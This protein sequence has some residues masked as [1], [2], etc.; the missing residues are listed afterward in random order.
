[1]KK[2]IISILLTA[3]M[4]VCLVPTGAF[5]ADSTNTQYP[6]IYLNTKPISNPTKVQSGSN[7]H[8]E[9]NSYIYFGDNGGEPIK[10]RVLDA[11]KANDGSKNGMFLM[12]EYLLDNN[13][14]YNYVH[15][16]SDYNG[17]DAQWWCEGF[18]ANDARFSDLERE[19]MLSVE[20]NDNVEK[21]LFDYTWDKCSL[22]DADKM[23]F[24]SIRE[25][26]DYVGNYDKAPG[27]IAA[28]TSGNKGTWWLR[29]HPSGYEKAAGLIY[30]TGYVD[31]DNVNTVHSARPALNLNKNNISFISAAVGGKSAEGTDGGLVEIPSYSGNEW[32]LTLYDSSR[33]DFYVDTKAVS[34][35][36][37]GGEISIRYGYAKNGRN[38]YISAILF[39]KDGNAKYYG[40]SSVFSDPIFSYVGGSGK[41]QIP[42]GLAEGEY[43]FVVFSEQY[44]GDYKTDYI[45]DSYSVR[46][47]VEKK[48]EEQFSLATGERYYFDL[49][50]FNFPG[51]TNEELPDSTLR[52]V[53]FIYAGTVNSYVL[54][55]ESSTVKGSSEYASKITDPSLSLYGYTYPHSLF[56]AEHTIK[57]GVMWYELQ[58]ASC[59]Y[60]ADYQ[61]GGIDY[62]LRAPTV[63]SAGNSGDGGLPLRNEWDR[64]LDKNSNFIKNW[65]G[66]GSWGQDLVDSHEGVDYSVHRG[67]GKS[68]RNWVD[69]QKSSYFLSSCY[70]P[71]LEVKNADALGRNGLR[72][73]TLNFNGTTVGSE[74]EIKIVVKSGG[75][76]TAPTNDGLER[77]YGWNYFGWLGD[78]NRVYA[79]GDSVPENVSSLTAQWI[80]PEEFRLEY[81]VGN[82][83]YFDLSGEDIPGTVDGDLPDT[84]LHYVP[85]TY[86]GTIEAYKLKSSSMGVVEAAEIASEADD[87]ESMYGYTQL[88]SLF[89]ADR[90]LTNRVSWTELDKKGLIF[91][92]DYTSNGINYT[93]RAPSMGSSYDENWNNLPSNNE[94]DR[95]L[96]K[97]PWYIKNMEIKSGKDLFF[98]WGQDTRIND[99]GTEYMVLRYEKTIGNR[100][101]DDA[102]DGAYRPVLEVQNAAAL[103]SDGL[104]EVVLYLDGGSLDGNEYINLMVKNS[105]SFTAPSKEGL[106]P[107]N[108]S[109]VFAGWVDLSS[110]TVYQ[111]GDSVPSTVTWLDATW[112][113]HTHCICGGNAY[114]GHDSH[115]NIDWKPWTATDSLPTEAGY[116]FLLNDVTLSGTVTLPDGVNICLNGNSI[117]GEYANS[118][119]L[120][121]SGALGI[122]D[123]S[124]EGSIGE[125]TLTGNGAELTLYGGKVEESTFL[126][127]SGGTA[128]TITGKA[129]SDGFIR[130]LDDADFTMN[131]EAENNSI[132]YFVETSSD[133][134]IKFGGHAKGGNVFSESTQYGSVISLD[135]SAEI[136]SLSG[137]LASIALYVKNDAKI[138]DVS[139]ITFTGLSLSENAKAGSEDSVFTI[140]CRNVLLKDNVQL[141]GKITYGADRE[142]GML[143]LQDKASIS[144]NLTLSN[145]GGVKTPVKVVMNGD[146]TVHG[147]IQC[148]DEAVSFEMQ[149]NAKIDGSIDAANSVFFGTVTCGGDI[150]SGV[151]DQNGTVINN[152]RIVGGIFYGTVMGTG[153]IEQS[154]KRTVTFVPNGGMLA[155]GER[156]VDILRGQKAGLPTTCHRDGYTLAGW[157][158]GDAAYDFST[159]VLEEITLTA[160]WTANAYTVKFDA[161]VGLQTADKVLHWEDKVLDGVNAPTRN[162]GYKFV[163]WMCGGEIVDAD[164]TYEKLAENDTVKSIT[165]TAQWRDIEKPVGEIVVKDNIWNKLLNSITFGLFFKETQTVTITASDNS[166]GNVT[167]EYLY[168]TKEH[169]DKEMTE[170]ELNARRVAAFSGRHC[171]YTKLLFGRTTEEEDCDIIDHE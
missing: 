145:A 84:S 156:A 107:P 103:G 46:F 160:Q 104:K 92:R 129:Q 120:N 85:F 80:E 75:S 11:D 153:T 61:S 81:G 62:T 119:K 135:G 169:K 117:K 168:L 37:D 131:G 5:A 64:I 29:S 3:C 108:D 13:V 32:K 6:A 163:H 35:T 18:V 34:V 27:F 83:Y 23:F 71:V 151:F 45:S 16:T 88:H 21:T 22:T 44:N 90:T 51:T 155:M 137:I 100:Q 111:P 140:E 52:Y 159:P 12:S 154:A 109:L 162:D 67:D 91:G 42:A 110:G 40:R 78:N 113:R 10:W 130:V 31:V 73:V 26:I 124:G 50:S 118:T 125:M 133:S 82:T 102:T 115:E 166:G 49:S 68:V 157:N 8:F 150:I 101:K 9:P 54:T 112:E 93:M 20:K 139:N 17:S 149:D 56:I 24:P 79:P 43:N 57:T 167:I 98:Y 164:T 70:R 38:E 58:R 144:G 105:E 77:P 33:S 132:I 74:E 4:L 134:R 122:T 59:I 63:G 99:N 165:L 28:D 53:P 47:T 97:A 148:S 2:R 126:I 72:A 147:N 114:D 69:A 142:S 76:F 95:I 66:Y 89:I 14:K 143:T 48:T 60:G 116:Y 25:I 15:G 65:K 152:G 1:M 128:F 96:A 158:K 127:I 7:I 161:K 55:F 86:V 106:V 123:C 121:A 171:T 146:S 94:W 170:E 87:P 36:T 30:D 136:S 41:F 138:G 39:D 19:A 141:I